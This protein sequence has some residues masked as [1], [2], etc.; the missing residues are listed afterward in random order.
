M[1]QDP[2]LLVDDEA[3][4]RVFLTDAL[5]RDG[6]RVEQAA[7]AE[8]ALAALATRHYPVVLTDLNMPGGLTGF[9]LIQAVKAKDPDALC[10]VI[11]GYASL[12]TA[13]RA[14]KFGAYDFVQKPFRLA[15]IEAV[16]D[17]ALSHA[18]VLAQLRGYRTDLE[19]R[20]LARMKELQNFHEEV[21]RLNDLL[22]AS[23]ACLEEAPILQPFMDHLAARVQPDGWQAL[24]PEGDAGW[25]VVVRG[26]E[27]QPDLAALPR[28]RDLV[29]DLEGAWPGA[30]PDN[31]L[32]PLR[33][34]GL[35][36][37]A[38]HLGFE[39]RSGFRPDAPAFS[40]WRRQV[41]AALH[42][43]HRAR[44]LAGR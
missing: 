10:V 3:D 25:R 31:H 36:L 24:L 1:I 16:L 19:A 43:L 20:V 12:E 32:L 18:E 8:A 42:G 14:V 39:D 27:R 35:L 38:V 17:R 21:E 28:P 9:D 37:G 13:V 15:E 40:L 11:T 23:Q 4:L 6:Y 5:T 26:G 22:V 7:G 44:A 33:G 34:P 30:W 41:E 2:I 29:A